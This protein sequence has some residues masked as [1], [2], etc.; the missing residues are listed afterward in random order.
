MS[1]YDGG[2]NFSIKSN[3]LVVLKTSGAVLLSEFQA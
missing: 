2:N 3:T 1:H